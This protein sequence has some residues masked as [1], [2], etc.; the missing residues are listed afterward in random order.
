MIKNDG[1]GSTTRYPG[2]HSTN[3][4]TKAK[5]PTPDAGVDN[6]PA[7]KPP[8]A[9]A[10]QDTY[11]APPVKKA[12]VAAPTPAAS[13]STTSRRA[14]E[15][16]APTPS[17]PP[18]K[19]NGLGSLVSAAPT[20]PAAPT[21]WTTD[22]SGAPIPMDAAADNQ[23]PGQGML[24]VGG[25]QTYAAG[26]VKGMGATGQQLANSV[27]ESAPNYTTDASGAPMPTEA[28]TNQVLA[29]A[30]RAPR[31]PGVVASVLN[32]ARD[33]AGSVLAG[34]STSSGF[35]TDASG[36]PIPDAAAATRIAQTMD[37]V[38]QQASKVVDTVLHD[39]DATGQFLGSTLAN[40]ASLGL[41]ELNLGLK[42][43][44]VV[45]RAAVVAEGAR[46]TELVEA[47]V[48]SG[49]AEAASYGR[50]AEGRALPAR[51]TPEG[52]VTP[53]GMAQLQEV[54][55]SDVKPT[56][57]QAVRWRDDLNA[58]VMTRPT[59][60]PEAR[61][62]VTSASSKLD[63]II[64]DYEAAG[65]ARP[66]RGELADVARVV[67]SGDP[68]VAHAAGIP[69]KSDATIASKLTKPLNELSPEAQGY[70]AGKQR[71]DIA[72][73]V[74]DLA[75]TDAPPEGLMQANHLTAQVWDQHLELEGIYRA[76]QVHGEAGALYQEIQTAT[77]LKAVPVELKEYVAGLRADPNLANQRMVLA[78]FCNVAASPA[79]GESVAAAI[80]SDLGKPVISNTGRTTIGTADLGA[81][82]VPVWQS[83]APRLGPPGQWTVTFPDGAVRALTTSELDAMPFLKNYGA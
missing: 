51:G 21:A 37:Q 77:G 50:A 15:L 76:P 43:A 20:A 73:L 28:V 29:D 61:A 67:T 16:P 12:P 75:K 72:S 27:M 71:E 46:A 6:T 49:G 42:G 13:A 47:G 4:T 31:G 83:S 32:A 52:L 33:V 68:A 81:G 45:E 30:A 53:R 14:D 2:S 59:M 63:G 22:A 62:M 82:P 48:A 44:A 69:L 58:A 18:M 3:S 38:G 17:L 34:A 5:G 60:A 65:S 66:I 24:N 25:F 55:A 35:T 19:V 74:T 79:G 10:S 26:I 39:P 80:A 78:P 70:W 23:L 11:V 1:G 41:G 36:A 56:L 57:N 7:K 64:A 9:P 54:L 40:V 8:K